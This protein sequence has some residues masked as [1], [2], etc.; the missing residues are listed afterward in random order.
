MVIASPV[1]TGQNFGEWCPYGMDGEMP[2]DQRPDDGRSVVFD[3]EALGDA[4]EILGAACVDLELASDREAA[5][6]AIRLEEVAPDGAATLVTYGLLNLTHRRGHARVAAIVPGARMVIRVALNDIAHRFA[7]GNRIRLALATGHWPIAWPSPAPVRL[8]LWPGAGALS[9]PVRV[10]QAS[11]R[12]LPAFAAPEQAPLPAHEI[13]KPAR[14]SRVIREDPSTGTT[15]IIVRRERP[16]YHLAETGLEVSIEACELYAVREGDP[17][18]TT[19]ETRAT[20]R[21]AR[22]AWSTRTETSTK[23]TCTAAQFEI[24]ASLDAFEGERAV[25]SRSWHRRIPR[26]GV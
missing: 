10:P 18:A 2:V 25:A 14:R 21:M 12:D 17:Q 1:A 11:D 7:A 20:W 13:R 26:M 22:G 9:L 19:A 16:S 4:V 8:T 15:E 3:G 5:M 23:I 24:T 6:I